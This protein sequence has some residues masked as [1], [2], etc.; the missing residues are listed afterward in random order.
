MRPRPADD[1]TFINP[2]TTCRQPCRYDR[3]VV[4]RNATVGN[5]LEVVGLR[6]QTL[7]RCPAFARPKHNCALS[8]HLA[9]GATA[10]IGEYPESRS[11]S[12]SGYISDVPTAVLESQPA[13]QQSATYLSLSQ[14]RPWRPIMPLQDDTYQSRA[15]RLPMCRTGATLIE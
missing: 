2:L 12:T 15:T 10:E 6:A 1:A 13:S 14:S 7:S 11:I 8:R 3:S 5:S 9:R 4:S